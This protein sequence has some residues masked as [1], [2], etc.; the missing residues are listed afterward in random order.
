MVSTTTFNEKFKHENINLDHWSTSLVVPH[1]QSKLWNVLD[2]LSTL[3]PK[4]QKFDWK[5][6]ELRD[7][8]L[9][10]AMF[11]CINFLKEK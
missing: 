2:G 7:Y 6:I 4:I 5:C 10:E 3:N 11:T 1:V 8:F 9:P